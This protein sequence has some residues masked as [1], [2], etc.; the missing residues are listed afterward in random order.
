MMKIREWLSIANNTNIKKGIIRVGIGALLL[1]NIPIPDGLEAQILGLLA[2]ID[3]VW[4]ASDA[5]K[6]QPQPERAP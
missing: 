2:I 4:T 6:R 5:Q 3:G 1:M